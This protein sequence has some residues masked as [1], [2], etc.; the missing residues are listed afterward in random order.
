MSRGYLLDTNTILWWFFGAEVLSMPSFDAIADRSIDVY[1]SAVSA[2][3]VAT[4]FRIGKLPLAAPIAGKFAEIMAEEGFKT[5]E[6]TLEHGDL[7]GSFPST[8]AD[9]WDRLLAAQALIEDLT[10]VTNDPKMETFGI[11][12]YW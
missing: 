8:H 11:K 3:E 12:P 7:A 1:V 5:L 4:K 9:P 2:I 6:L 10:L